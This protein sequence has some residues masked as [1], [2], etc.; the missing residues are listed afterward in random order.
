[1]TLHSSAITLYPIHPRDKERPRTREADQVP[2]N[3][4]HWFP[5]DEVFLTQ[6]KEIYCELFRFRF[7]FS[8]R[9]QY[10]GSF[11]GSGSNLANNCLEAQIIAPP[12]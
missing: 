2:A 6:N 4:W 11:T 9:S 7:G 5:E 12:A 3:T 8:N 1:M 10:S